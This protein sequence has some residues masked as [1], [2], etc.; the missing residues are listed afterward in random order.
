MSF[1][2]GWEIE[3]GTGTDPETGP[4]GN[5]RVMGVSLRTPQINDIKRTLLKVNDSF[6][7]VDAF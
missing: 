3:V 1:G 2:L 7:N 5:Q 6:D 4:F